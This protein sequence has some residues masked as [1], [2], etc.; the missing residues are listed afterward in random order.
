MSTTAFALVRTVLLVASLFVGSSGAATAKGGD[1]S[2]VVVSFHVDASKSRTV[3]AFGPLSEA[4]WSPDFKPRFVYPRD[5]RQVAGAVFTTSDGRVWLLHDYD[6]AAGIV[7]YVIID[8]NAEVTLTIHVVTAGAG[9]SAT[10][11]YDVVALNAS[12]AEHI[13]TLHDHAHELSMHLQSAIGD[14]LAKSR[15]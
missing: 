14:Y 12:G 3:A 13:V 7:Q 10:M 5:P 4:S 11:T 15:P 2:V 8:A 9:S 1:H 6:I